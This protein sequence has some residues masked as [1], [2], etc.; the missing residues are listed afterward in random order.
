MSLVDPPNVD[1]FKR[2]ANLVFWLLL[3]LGLLL[4][5]A[6]ADFCNHN[7]STVEFWE[8]NY[9]QIPGYV[10]RVEGKEVTVVSRDKN[11]SKVLILTMDSETEPKTPPVKGKGYMFAYCSKC[12]LM[13][14][15][16]QF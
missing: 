7:P 13:F 5:V 2:V 6:K 1:K 11:I 12:H 8:E 15:Y 9:R 3:F 10:T 4:F 16:K 14:G